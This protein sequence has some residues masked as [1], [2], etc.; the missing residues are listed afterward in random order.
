MVF[1]WV[2]DHLKERE[3]GVIP[4]GRKN[5][6]VKS[7][8]STS[9]RMSRKAS[10]QQLPL[11]YL[12]HFR[13]HLLHLSESILNLRVHTRL[14]DVAEGFT[15]WSQAEDILGLYFKVVPERIESQYYPDD[16]TG[17]IMT[18]WRLIIRAAGF[19]F[20]LISWK[21]VFY[22]HKSR[23]ASIKRIFGWCWRELK[24]KPVERV[25]KIGTCI[26]TSGH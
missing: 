3:D 4:P 23:F 7:N 22:L 1:Q 6:T 21:S 11:L 10:Q 18:A 13:S 19:V 16:E 12:N 9:S 24:G 2:E 20:W 8:A 5:D 14:C 26:A 17:N 25:V 15:D